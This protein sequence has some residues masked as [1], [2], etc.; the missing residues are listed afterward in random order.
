MTRDE[1][2][3][4]TQVPNPYLFHCL[5]HLSSLVL[6]RVGDPDEYVDNSPFTWTEG[7]HLYLL[8]RF[9]GTDQPGILGPR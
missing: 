8:D 5:S 4:N 9:G 3:K 2:Y 6:H 1:W 7:V